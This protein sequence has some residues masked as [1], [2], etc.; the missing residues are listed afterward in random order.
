[1]RIVSTLF[2]L[3]LILLGVTFAGLNA[4]P[5]AVNYYI[6]TAKLPLSLLLVVTLVLG[7]LL[8]LIFNIISYIKLKSANLRLRQRLKLAEEE[9]TNLR[10]M[11]L[12]DNH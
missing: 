11:P 6:G 1:M 9:I 8:G 10:T 12:K 5:I 2:L 3:L 7:G 4:E